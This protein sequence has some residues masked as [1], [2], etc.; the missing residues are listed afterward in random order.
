MFYLQRGRLPHN[1]KVI[2]ALPQV[3][4][5][6]V[7]SLWSFILILKWRKKKTNQPL[8]HFF[9]TSNNQSVWHH[10]KPETDKKFTSRKKSE[11]TSEL[12]TGTPG[13]LRL[14]SEWC[15]QSIQAARLSHKTFCVELNSFK[16]RRT[17][18]F[19]WTKILKCVIYSM[20]PQFLYEILAAESFPNVKK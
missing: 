7:A 2:F 11:G 13:G 19:S 3:P 10:S 8:W 18:F 6:Q 16:H 14:R 17:P 15:H 12:Q 4:T 9:F 1:L 20:L 5:P